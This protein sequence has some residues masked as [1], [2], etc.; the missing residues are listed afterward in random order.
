MATRPRKPADNGSDGTS[1]ISLN[2]VG[3]SPLM[4]NSP[5]GI[6]PRDPIGKQIKLITDKGADMTDEDQ[7]MVLRLKFEQSLYWEK[8]IGPYLPAYN[9]ITSFQKAAGLTRKGQTIVRGV[10]LI[11]SDQRPIEYDGPREIDPMWDAGYADVRP[12]KPRNA[13]AVL[14]SRAMFKVWKI[15]GLEVMLD[16]EQIN[17]RNF[18]GFAAL[19]GKVMG[20]GTYRRRYGRFAVWVDGEEIGTDGLPVPKG[21]M[22]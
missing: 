8:E 4:V 19:A 1:F 13:G 10:H 21:S 18:L 5:R 11:S 9:I 7:E 16:L 3:T 17:R 15:S 12:V 6:D 14:G 20:V 2:I 22:V